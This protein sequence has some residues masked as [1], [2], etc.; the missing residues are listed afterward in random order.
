MA[1]SAKIVCLQYLFNFKVAYGQPF[2]INI[3]I[4][5]TPMLY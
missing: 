4:A 5:W 2:L 3:L 1:I